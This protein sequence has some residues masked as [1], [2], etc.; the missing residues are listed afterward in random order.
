[1][2]TRGRLPEIDGVKGVKGFRQLN[3]RYIFI[4]KNVV[5]ENNQF[6]EEIELSA[7]D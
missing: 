2:N 6:N 7:E 5:V 1:M 3:Y 4:A